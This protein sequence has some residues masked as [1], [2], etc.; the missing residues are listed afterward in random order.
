MV[1][2]RS[3]SE[4]RQINHR[5]LPHIVGAV[6]GSWRRS[7]RPQG[8]SRSETASSAASWGKNAFLAG[9]TSHLPGLLFQSV[10]MPPPAKTQ[11][12]KSSPGS[13]PADQVTDVADWYKDALSLIVLPV[14]NCQLWDLRCGICRL[15]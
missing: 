10:L 14:T 9:S 3:D 15:D 1:Q 12:I 5:S 2:G 13:Q 6:P 7:P 8:A 11:W 4:G